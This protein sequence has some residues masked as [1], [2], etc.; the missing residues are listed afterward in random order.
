MNRPL[1]GKQAAK[2]LHI[3]K[4]G[5]CADRAVCRALMKRGLIDDMRRRYE[6]H[7]WGRK[8]FSIACYS[9]SAEGERLVREEGDALRALRKAYWESIGGG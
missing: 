4:H 8:V 9:L 3:A 1:T 5:Y 2:L 7:E 6:R